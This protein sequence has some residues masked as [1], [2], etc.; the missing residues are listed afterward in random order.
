MGFIGVQSTTIRW[1]KGWILHIF[2][3]S[4]PQNRV[5]FVNQLV[6]DLF[7]G[8]EKSSLYYFPQ[9]KNECQ[10]NTVC[11]ECARHLYTNS[12]GLFSSISKIFILFFLEKWSKKLLS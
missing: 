1:E 12:K 8:Q 4:M 3:W 5:P 9:K 11:V 7:L 10:F 6:W 2:V